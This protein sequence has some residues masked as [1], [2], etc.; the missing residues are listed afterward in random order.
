M[1]LLSDL[2][3]SFV[4]TPLSEEGVLCFA[5]LVLSFLVGSAA[6]I[7]LADV[8]ISKFVAVVGTVFSYSGCVVTR[9]SSSR[10]SSALYISEWAVLQRMAEG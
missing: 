7:V 8:G 1:W 9:G 5:V 6:L 3:V 2:E 10:S 4:C